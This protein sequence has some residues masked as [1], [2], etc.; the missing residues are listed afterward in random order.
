M[1]SS[2]LEF[3]RAGVKDYDDR[4]DR[5]D[6]RSAKGDGEAPL[7]VGDALPRSDASSSW[8]GRLTE[9]LDQRKRPAS[10][11]H[12][13]SAGDQRRAR[14]DLGA[15]PSAE[16]EP[17]AP[18]P[19]ASPEPEA[20]SPSPAEVPR[21]SMEAPSPRASPPEPEARSPS[22]EEVPRDSMTEASERTAE[23]SS[24]ASAHSMEDDES[25]GDEFQVPL[26]PAPPSRAPRTPETVWDWL[27]AWSFSPGS[28]EYREVALACDT[29]EDLLNLGGHPD[30]LFI[31]SGWKPLRR[32]RFL[33]AIGVPDARVDAIVPEEV[34]PRTADTSKRAA[35]SAPPEDEPPLA[36]ATRLKRCRACAACLAEDCGECYSCKHMKKFGGNGKLKQC[37]D[38]RKCPNMTAQP[39]VSYSAFEPKPLPS[40]AALLEQLGEYLAKLTGGDEADAALDGWS[41]LAETRRAGETAGDFDVYY[42]SPSGER[43]RSKVGVARHLGLA[44]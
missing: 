14:L 31:T 40:E 39:I 18:S 42:L 10:E 3:Y 13:A 26:R 6:D 1:V 2:L 29:L 20:R 41:A 30:L 37:C 16:A 19:R 11:C 27:E 28:V 4:S 36:Y 44:A 33:R 17:E 35:P 25:D 23:S 21:E 15:P 7:C 34:R 32:R 24:R 43:L 9:V 22:P 8:Q 5:S 38:R 12:E